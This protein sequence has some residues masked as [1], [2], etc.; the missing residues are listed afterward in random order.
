MRSHGN[1]FMILPDRL[2]AAA[3][4]AQEGFQ[5]PGAKLSDAA[6]AAMEEL[7]AEGKSR[8]CELFKEGPVS[9][10]VSQRER[11]RQPACSTSRPARRWLRLSTA[12]TGSCRWVIISSLS[13]LGLSHMTVP[14]VPVSAS[15]VQDAQNASGKNI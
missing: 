1:R 2:A 3:A 14:L 12:M 15:H 8:R 13:A 11:Q 5:Q 4:G 10:A 7:A 9:S 6:V